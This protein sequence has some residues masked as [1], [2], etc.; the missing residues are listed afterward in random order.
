MFAGVGKPHIDNSP[1]KPRTAK[2]HRMEAAPM[3]GEW[4]AW[5]QPPPRTC[6]ASLFVIIVVVTMVF[7]K[8]SQGI[9]SALNK[10]LSY[11]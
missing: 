2:S 11:V 4:T 5:G 7:N 10:Q 1:S 6:C 8:T 9:T 3:A